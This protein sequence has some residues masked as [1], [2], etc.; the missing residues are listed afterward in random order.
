[1]LFLIRDFILLHFKIKVMLIDKNMRLAD[2][3]HHDY[4]LLP[5]INRFDMHLGVGDK[6]IA[7]ICQEKKVNVDFFLVIINTFHDLQYFPTQQLQDFP[8]HILLNYLKQTH[9]YYLNN[10]LPEIELQIEKMEKNCDIDKETLSLLH[11][12]FIEYRNELSG[13]IER[14]EK[15]VY[16]YVLELEQ[17]MESGEVSEVLG[18]KMN[19]YA[20]TNYKEEHENVEEKLYDL[21]NLIIKYLPETNNDS[22][23]HLVL[24][25]LFGLERD[26]NNHSR[27]EN[28]I[29]VP[30]VEEIER[31]LKQN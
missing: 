29:L 22:F 28:L 2:I 15:V 27:M 9:F 12:F 24:R 4:T 23:C 25:E 26:L 17:A 1:M 13:H 20:I 21:K 31:K 10:V 18:K 19:S 30:K 7:G 8:V 3:I 6:T 16:P 14:E 11:N 5:V